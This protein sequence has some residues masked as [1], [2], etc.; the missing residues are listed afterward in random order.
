[1]LVSTGTGHIISP[2][3]VP[4]PVT[5]PDVSGKDYNDRTEPA[6]GTDMVTYVY[7]Y[8]AYSD[9]EF[10]LV[11]DKL[12][13]GTVRYQKT[14]N[15]ADKGQVL[16]Q[17]P[18]AGTIVPRETPVHIVVSTGN[19]DAADTSL[20]EMME[21]LLDAFDTLDSDG[22]GG[23]SWEEAQTARPDM[24]LEDF[25][26]LDA[27]SDG[28]LSP[29]ELGY[30]PPLC[31]I[32]SPLSVFRMLLLLE[33]NPSDP[34]HLSRAEF[35]T[36]RG[37]TNTQMN[38]WS[39]L[40]I[41][42]DDRVSFSE[43]DT[44]DWSMLNAFFTL[45]TDGDNAISL[46]EYQTMNPSM[47]AADFQT[48]AQTDGAPTLIDC[49]DLEWILISVPDTLLMEEDE[50]E[51]AI[52]DAGLAVESFIYEYHN[53][54]PEGYVIDQDPLSGT[55]LAPDG[56]VTVIISRGSIVFHP[57]D[58][59]ED[60]TI[61]GDEVEAYVKAWQKGPDPVEMEMA[62]RALY[63]NKLEHGGAYIF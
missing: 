60:G 32:T 16:R 23:L 22:S 53:T 15:A 61:D 10:L 19:D 1:M 25:E 11:V 4:G 49:D 28:E 8:E 47:V 14:G 59:S 45:D 31:T 20:D 18:A 55:L 21:E 51:K 33:D 48:A 40:D 5:V 62:V 29:E 12:V 50:A 54:V 35:Q 13:L 39:Q 30:I 58:T 27:D 36:L 52:L 46:H 44:S 17:M 34:G 43:F 26:T 41:N 38:G 6:P 9:A 7:P 3:F 2:V 42:G 37:L 63:I 57:A 56:R 24:W